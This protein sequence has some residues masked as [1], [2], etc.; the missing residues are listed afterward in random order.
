MFLPTDPDKT[1]RFFQ[2]CPSNDEYQLEPGMIGIK[3]VGNDGEVWARPPRVSSGDAEPDPVRICL[4]SDLVHANLSAPNGVSDYQH[5]PA[6]IDALTKYLQI[7]DGMKTGSSDKFT[8]KYQDL[9]LRRTGAVLGA[10]VG[11]FDVNQKYIAFSDNTNTVSLFDACCMDL[12]GTVG[13]VAVGQPVFILGSLFVINQAQY[14]MLSLP[15]LTKTTT[16]ISISS[17]SVFDVAA[18]SDGL[19]YYCDGST[20]KTL[21]VVTNSVASIG[22]LSGIAGTVYGIDVDVDGDRV[23]IADVSGTSMVIRTYQLDGT[24]ITSSSSY[25]VASASVSRL[26]HINDEIYVAI[27]LAGSTHKILIYSTTPTT[28]NYVSTAALSGT[29]GVISADGRYYCKRTSDN[30]LVDEMLPSLSIGTP[31]NIQ[32]TVKMINS[33]FDLGKLGHHSIA[34]FARAALNAKS[35]TETVGGISVLSVESSL[36]GS[37]TAGDWYLMD[38]TAGAIANMLAEYRAVE[39]WKF[40]RLKNGNTVFNI[41]SQEYLKYVDDGVFDGVTPSTIANTTV[42]G[43][44]KAHSEGTIGTDFGGVDLVAVFT[45]ETNTTDA[46]ADSAVLSLHAG[47]P[48]KFYTREAGDMHVFD[49]TIVAAADDASA[50]R[51]EGAWTGII[52]ASAWLGASGPT[53]FIYGSL[54]AHN[55][56]NTSATFTT[57]TIAFNTSNQLEITCE[58][59]G[60][61]ANIINVRWQAFIKCSVLKDCETT[62]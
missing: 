13:S 38:N 46:S 23:Y 52:R 14:H 28:P 47:D 50:G 40:Y 6:T 34:D 54:T 15:D 39:G 31:G 37:P 32:S 20:L 60:T 55:L 25:T 18:G 33:D 36:P 59:T 5:Y 57:P 24:P 30:L 42:N 43:P 62:C 44:I 12:L 49:V 27:G 19:I 35:L 51:N 53:P 10:A 4:V 58:H 1:P 21:D 29:T 2:P 3:D 26:R 8:A 48:T 16:A 56:V 17:A 41:E 45:G 22:A 9:S 11:Y 61:G 7:S